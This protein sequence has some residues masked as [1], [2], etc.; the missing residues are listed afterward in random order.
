MPRSVLEALLLRLAAQQVARPWWV[1]LLIGLSLLPAG[2]LAADL[3]LRT[4]FS[5][6]LPDDKPSVV[7][8]RRVNERLPGNSTLTV[9][10]TGRDAD[11]LKRFVDALA[12]RIRALGPDLVASVDAGPR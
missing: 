10:A 8:M 12:P 1:I 2:W 4:S 9:V 3:P 11:S 5:E 6:L 7:E